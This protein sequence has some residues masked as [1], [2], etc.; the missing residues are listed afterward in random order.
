MFSFARTAAVAACVVGYFAV[1]ADDAY[2]AA[3]PTKNIVQLAPT[4]NIVQLAQEVPEL[5][6]LVELVVAGGLVDTL[7]GPGP[8]TVFA[9]LNRAFER[10]LGNEKL[11]EL[12]DPK[13]KDELVK[14]LTYHVVSGSV[15]AKDITD[16]E[17]IATVEGDNV[18]A[19]IYHYRHYEILAINH[20]R[21]DEADVDATN[22]VVHTVDGV[23]IPW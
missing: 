1:A 11:Q 10:E 14:I 21:V 18:T 22:G 3:P 7:S 23:L 8:F 13:N 17:E 16:H 20:A 19:Y 6:I 5:S 9:P 15:H 12:L 2:S 4:K